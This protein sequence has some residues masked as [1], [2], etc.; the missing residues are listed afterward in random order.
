MRRLE[1]DPPPAT[2]GLLAGPPPGD[3]PAAPG[4]DPFSDLRDWLMAPQKHWLRSLGL[5]PGEWERRVD[6]LEALVL[7]ERERSALLRGV[8]QESETDPEQG[9]PGSAA[10]WLARH[11]GRGLLP[12]KGAGPIAA[13]AL[14]RR[15]G[16][17]RAAL[18]TLGP[19]R[20]I[21]HHW[22]PWQAA[23]PWRGEAVVLVHAARARAGHRLALWLQLLLAAAGEDPGAPAP[24]RGVLIARNDDQFTPVAEF[25]PPEAPAARA[26]LERLAALQQSWRRSGWPVPPG[27]GWCYVAAE[28]KKPGDGRRRAAATWEGSGFLRGEREQ[29]EMAVCF[30]AGLPA[31]ALLS[32]QLLT[33]ADDLLAPVLAAMGTA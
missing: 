5:R 13:E 21:S 16:S 22:G 10:D 9:S 15:W 24:R 17:L 2:K 23:I 8:L 25:I 26:E 6:D 19:P 29:E 18:E 27:T 7:E 30:G 1:A 12:P 14:Q 20:Q 33:L 11:R 32:P 28:A 4:A 3:P 31:E